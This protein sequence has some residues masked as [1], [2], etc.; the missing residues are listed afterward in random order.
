M[1]YSPRYRAVGKISHA[2]LNINRS[3]SYQPVQDL[4]SKQLLFDLL[5]DPGRFYDHNRRYSASVI[6]SVT[7]GHRIPSWDNELAREVYKV[8]NNMQHYAAS[9]T[10]LV[11]TFPALAR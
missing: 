3:V 6:I 8:V 2:L 4:E 11:D 7:Y 9:G 5:R 10:W 1:P